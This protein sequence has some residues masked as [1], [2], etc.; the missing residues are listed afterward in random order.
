MK[1]PC[2]TCGATYGQAIP[3]RPDRCGVCITGLSLD[4]RAIYPIPHPATGRMVCPMCLARGSTCN[5]V[6]SEDYPDA[7]QHDLSHLFPDVSP[8]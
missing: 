4:G 3:N 8:R 1:D 6:P 7:W 5:L 2:R